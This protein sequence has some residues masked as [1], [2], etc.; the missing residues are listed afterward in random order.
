VPRAA[1]GDASVRRGSRLRSRSRWSAPLCSMA[2]ASLKVFLEAGNDA[3]QRIRLFPSMNVIALMGRRPRHDM[4]HTKTMTTTTTTTRMRGTLVLVRM[5]GARPGAQIRGADPIRALA[6]RRR[7]REHGQRTP[8]NLTTTT[9]SLNSPAL[10][11]RRKH[12]NRLHHP[13]DGQARTS[14][15]A[16][17]HLRSERVHCLP[18]LSRL[19]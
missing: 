16:H 12:P 3:P 10:A 11:Q 18:R 9:T 7:C 5:R 1:R 14:R 13:R 8:H 6:R 19:A 4:F 2:T 17:R 15:P